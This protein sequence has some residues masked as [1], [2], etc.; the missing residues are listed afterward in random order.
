LKLYIAVHKQQYDPKRLLHRDCKTPQLP[1]DQLKKYQLKVQEQTIPAAQV[2]VVDAKEER[3]RKQKA[4]GAA[5]VLPSDFSKSNERA[6]KPKKSVE[7]V[8]VKHK[9][10]KLKV[11]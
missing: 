7:T 8:V 6:K 4:S 9:D 3:K 2:I 1:D 10:T 11:I 5:A